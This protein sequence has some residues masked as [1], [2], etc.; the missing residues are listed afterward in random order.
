M[1]WHLILSM[2]VW[3]WLLESTVIAVF[4]GTFGW[5]TSRL[6]GQRA[7]PICPAHPP[8]AQTILGAGRAKTT[9]LCLQHCDV[10]LFKNNLIGWHC[11]E[12]MLQ[13]LSFRGCNVLQ[14]LCKVAFGSRVGV[15]CPMGGSL[16]IELQ[17]NKILDETT[18]DYKSRKLDILFVNCNLLTFA[19]ILAML[20]IFLSS[21]HIPF[22]FLDSHHLNGNHPR[23]NWRRGCETGG[24][25]DHS[26]PLGKEAKN[27]DA[28]TK[29]GMKFLHNIGWVVGSW[30]VN[31]FFCVNM[32][33]FL[34]YLWCWCWCWSCWCWLSVPALCSSSFCTWRYWKSLDGRFRQIA[35]RR[36]QRVSMRKLLVDKRW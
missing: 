22:A 29:M 6:V 2:Q 13:L 5:R 32:H 16:T 19:Y 15:W 8:F 12:L 1:I 7:R 10:L 26:E 36:H 9:I 17:W 23:P 35:C 31:C 30:L 34:F 11:W 24:E 25:L 33:C 18:P 4:W 20:A 28:W 14:M 21:F 3:H 27:L